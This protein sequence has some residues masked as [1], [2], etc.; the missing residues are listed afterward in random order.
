MITICCLKQ[1]M[2][3]GA[4]Y[5]NKL[6]SMVKRNITIPFDFVCFTDISK[7]IDS[8][9]RVESLPY[10]APYWWGKMG[11]Y[12]AKIDGVNTEKLLFFDLDVVIT[13]NIDGLCRFESDFA[14]AKDYPYHSLSVYDKRQKWGNTSVLLLTVGSQ[15]K[16][17]ETYIKKGCSLNEKFGDQEWINENFYG[18]CDLIPERFV[19]SYKLHEL[20]GDEIPDCQVVMFHGRPKPHECGGW[21]AELWR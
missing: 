11:L 14:C 3:Y 18:K 20:A 5:V 1:G 12:K 6:F 21:V 7:G 4:E 10:N 15:A 17:W 16:I 13:G 19:K 2:K 8:S 9:V